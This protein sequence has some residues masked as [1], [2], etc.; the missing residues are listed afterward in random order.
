MS[1]KFVLEIKLFSFSYG[2]RK[3]TCVDSLNNYIG[4]PQ[5]YQPLMQSLGEGSALLE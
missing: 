2:Y 1:K 5:L 3:C 4:L